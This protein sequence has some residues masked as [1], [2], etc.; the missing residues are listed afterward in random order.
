LAISLLLLLNLL[1]F[2]I[3]PLLAPAV[4]QGNHNDDNYHTTNG[5][6]NRPTDT[7]F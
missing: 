6:A 3:L 5:T 7:R 4:A 2:G 1:Q